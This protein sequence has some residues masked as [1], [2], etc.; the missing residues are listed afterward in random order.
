MSGRNK[1]TLLCAGMGGESQLIVPLRREGHERRQ[2]SSISLGATAEEVLNQ[3]NFSHNGQGVW[4]VNSEQ[5]VHNVAGDFTLAQ[6][7][8]A[9]C[10]QKSTLSLSAILIL[11]SSMASLARGDIQHRETRYKVGEFLCGGTVCSC[12]ECL[13]DVCCRSNSF[14]GIRRS[15]RARGS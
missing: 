11:T 13:H 4:K 2:H 7:W 12:S 6:N 14:L 15:K 1:G 5:N 8:E 9:D 3:R 10:R